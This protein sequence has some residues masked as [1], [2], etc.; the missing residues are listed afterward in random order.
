[1]DENMLMSL[2]EAFELCYDDVLKL[3]ERYGEDN[4]EA[5]VKA[6]AKIAYY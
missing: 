1:M 3:Y 2:A 4:L 6:V 5:L